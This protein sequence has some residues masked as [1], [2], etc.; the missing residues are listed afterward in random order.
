M[1]T[2]S[3]GLDESVWQAKLVRYTLSAPV[4]DTLFGVPSRHIRR[5]TRAGH[6]V[7]HPQR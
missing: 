7:L 2:F 5:Q 4:S 6:W 1:T 3:T